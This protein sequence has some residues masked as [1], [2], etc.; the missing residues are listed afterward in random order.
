V[1]GVAYPFELLTHCGIE[2]A[3]F[4]GRYWLAEP[5]LDD[6]AHN[7]PPGWDNPTQ[8]GSMTLLFE[9]DRAEFRA[10]PRLVARFR[11][12]GPS[13]ERSGCA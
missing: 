2:Y 11:P 4:D 6:G 7:P 9:G 5:P 10:G 12:G 8:R 3:F 13:Y 1:P